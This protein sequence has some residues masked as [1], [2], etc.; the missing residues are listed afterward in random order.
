MH[1]VN[2]RIYKIMIDNPSEITEVSLPYGYLRSGDGMFLDG[3]ELVVV[4]NAAN[5]ALDSDPSNPVVPFV[6]KFMT[7]D[8][9]NSAVPVGDTYATGDVFPTT[10][11]K[12]GEDYFINYA[13]FNFIAY[14]NFPVD[15]LISKANFDLNQRYSGSAT[16]IPRVNTPVVPFSYGED[17][18]EPYYTD[19]TTPITDGVPDFSGDWVETT[20]TIN[21]E[22][23][24]AQPDTRR[25]RIEQCGSRILIASDG[26][27]HEVFEA[28]NTM[29][30][31]VNDVDP[32]GIPVHLTGRFEDDI[33]ILTPVVTDT[34]LIVPDITRELIQDDDENDVLKLF[35]PLLGGTRYLREETTV[36]TRNLTVTKNFKVAPNPFQNQTLV[37]WNNTENAT[38]QA[39]LLN[40]TGQVVRRYSNV[41]G[42]SLR[43]EKEDLLPGIYFLNI[44]DGAGNSGTVKLLLLE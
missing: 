36:A 15:Y 38:F 5:E 21:G 29:F 12:V 44:I 14:Q 1:S 39:Q 42:E 31:G 37:T 22:E 30:N 10:V 6:T 23:I 41:Q 7:S 28:D 11:V 33:L 16:E 4:S 9:W 3:D 13:Y 25:E 18:P 24:A 2:D 17:Y 8:N 43:V 35:N 19:C 34:T 27:L 20:V 26:V 40:V 32:T